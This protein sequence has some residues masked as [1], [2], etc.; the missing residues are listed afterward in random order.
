MLGLDFDAIFEVIMTVWLLQHL[1]LYHASLSQKAFAVGKH[2]CEN[3]RDIA[4]G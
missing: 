1:R 2:V 3:M 4:R